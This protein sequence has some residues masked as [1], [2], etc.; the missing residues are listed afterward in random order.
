MAGFSSIIFLHSAFILSSA[1]F[2]SMVLQ[3]SIFWPCLR[4]SWRR[5][6]QRRSRPWKQ[7]QKTRQSSSTSGSSCIDSLVWVGKCRSKLNARGNYVTAMA[8]GFHC[9]IPR[10]PRYWGVLTALAVLAWTGPAS[11]PS[12]AGRSAPADRS[13]RGAGAPADAARRRHGA[14]TGRPSGGRDPGGHRGSG[15]SAP[16]HPA[17]RALLRSGDGARR[18]AL[19]RLCRGGRGAVFP[20][21]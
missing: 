18:P 21:P 12:P 2:G 16:R 1:F 17:R 5:R 8:G 3:A 19:H 14:R 7:W 10:F 4:R 13:G 9:I 11:C 6:A 15:R 20:A